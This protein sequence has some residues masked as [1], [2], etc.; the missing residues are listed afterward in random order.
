[1]EPTAATLA[2]LRNQVCSLLG[3][4]RVRAELHQL[5]TRPP[6]GAPP[7]PRAY[8]ELG[9][10][11]LLAP[12]WPAVFGGRGLGLAA[13][14]VVTEE[15]AHHGVPGNAHTLSVDIVGQV[16]LSHG[17]AEQRGRYLPPIARG[18]ATASVLYTEPEAGSDLAALT[19]SALRRGAGWQLRGR[20][21]YSV[22][23]QTA[24]W[25]LCAARTGGPESGV[26]GI[27]LFLV[28]LAA[29]G[30]HIREVPTALEEPFTEV[31]LDGVTVPDEQVVGPVDAGWAILSAC[32]PFERTGVDLAAKARR[33]W[34]VL[35]RYAQRRPDGT[36]QATVDRLVDLHI[37]LRAGR[38]L[39]RRLVDD[40]ARGN[41]DDS[42][43]ATSK[44]FNAQVAIDVADM[45]PQVAGASGLLSRHDP[46]AAG[47]GLL[48]AAVREAPG[49]A[50]SAG[51]AEIMLGIVA[52]RLREE[53]E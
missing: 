1:V 53:V 11:R 12:G 30:V 49:L 10:R 43:A 25:G 14:V 45:G 44:W 42:A 15:L 7:L 20:K 40:L 29:P 39:A 28:D 9:A 16:L 34:S 35:W 22:T 50:V 47:G 37:R 19:T 38:A 17:S 21:S 41:T 48:E 33:W 26:G 31:V 24:T 46:E 3:G 18:E 5:R 2:S 6:G 51:T 52:A 23:S 32:L 4:P 36:D 8:R 27:T 13:S